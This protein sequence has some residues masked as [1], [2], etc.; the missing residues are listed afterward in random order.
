[1]FLC[2]FAARIAAALHHR[3]SSPHRHRSVRARA[4]SAEV[5]CLPSAA[6]C[7]IIATILKTV[8]SSAAIAARARS[9]VENFC[10]ANPAR[11]TCKWQTGRWQLVRFDAGSFRAAQRR[12]IR[13]RLRAREVP[14]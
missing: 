2:A 9:T 13:R 4:R 8:R 6:R 14:R 3:T 12:S 11:A 7:L 10:G 1:V 5:M